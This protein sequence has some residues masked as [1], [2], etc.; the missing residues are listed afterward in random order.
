M[1]AYKTSLDTLF[2]NEIYFATKLDFKF[3]L[4]HNT[5]IESWGKEFPVGR[6]FSTIS[7]C[8]WVIY[9]YS[10]LKKSSTVFII[11]KITKKMLQQVKI[12]KMMDIGMT[13]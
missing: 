3:I 13:L 8:N 2:Y 4:P 12:L 11:T 1:S 9:K 7:M 6:I 5:R 10:K